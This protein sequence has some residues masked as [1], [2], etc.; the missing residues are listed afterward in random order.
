MFHRVRKHLTTPSTLIALLALI[1]AVTG[2]SYAATGGGGNNK[3]ALTAH[4]SKTKRGARGPAG[5]AGP[6]GKEGKEGKAGATG[7]TGKEGAAGKEGPAG[8][9]GINGSLVGPAGES[10]LVS[11]IGSGPECREGGAKFTDA[12]G[13]AFACNAEPVPGVSVTSA[14]I[15]VGETACNKQGGVEYTAF[16][17][18]KATICNGTNGTNGESVTSDQFTGGH[19]P[20]TPIN[21]PC[22]TA[23]GSEFKIGTATPTY[24]CNGSGGGG[25]SEGYP[26][27]LPAE[28]S[29]TGTWV[30]SFTV[31]AGE[32]GTTIEYNG[33]GVAISFPIHLAKPIGPEGATEG[34]HVVGAGEQ[35]TTCPGTVENP[36]AEPGNFCIYQGPVEEEPAGTETLTIN[37]FT[38]VPPGAKLNELTPGT[39]V[40]GAVAHIHYEGQNAGPVAIQGTWAVT[41]PKA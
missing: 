34:V 9:A 39:G 7:A 5:P 25:S 3:N 19:E 14:E 41:A 17:G 28:K 38:I 12:T 4:T 24:A 29:E 21:E 33:P 10:V 15:K 1:F 11:T 2:V 40:S 35:S 30:D 22:K 18:K 20:T 37:R 27:T 36:E 31:P 13:T 23:G 6:A 26:K 32:P 8:P 16:E